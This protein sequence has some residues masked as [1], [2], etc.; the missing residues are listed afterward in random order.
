MKISS[1]ALNLL[2][3]DYPSE[4]TFEVRGG[5][6]A[7]VYVASRHEC[8]VLAD[9]SYAVGE[10]NRRGL[11][12]LALVVPPRVAL[13]KLRRL[14]CASGRTVAEASQLT[15]KSRILGG[16]VYSHFAKR[17]QYYSPEWRAVE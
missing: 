11:K 16:I 6:G 17:T 13:A 5:D 1:R 14:V 2:L 3:L 4:K 15:V 7:L 9:L 8:S 12:Y 10:A